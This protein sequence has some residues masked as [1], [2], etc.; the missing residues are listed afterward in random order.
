MDAPLWMM[1]IEEEF[2]NETLPI[3][4][5][6][7]KCVQHNHYCATWERYQKFKPRWD[8]LFA[9]IA[10]AYTNSGDHIVESG[11]AGCNRCIQVKAMK[12]IINSPDADSDYADYASI[13]G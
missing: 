6:Y 2:K 3:G 8:S 4:M 10:Q 11:C 12:D 7:R 13:Y 9:K 5:L 1:H